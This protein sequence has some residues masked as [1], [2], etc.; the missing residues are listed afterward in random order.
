MQKLF[1]TLLLA[2]ATV[3]ATAAPAQTGL[4]A[5]PQP[6]FEIDRIDITAHSPQQTVTLFASGNWTFRET[7]DDKQTNTWGG[8]LSDDPL[9][10][11]NADLA[12]AKWTQTQGIHCMARTSKST[13]YKV[14]GKSVF[15][16]M[17]CNASKLD[18]ASA[19]SLADLEQLLTPA[20]TKPAAQ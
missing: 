12:A 17:M 10:Q 14:D 15:T 5:S 6:I 16:A 4:R 2:A 13:V 8:K 19:K 11:A 7:V 1:V 20:W 3:S 9:K 18:D